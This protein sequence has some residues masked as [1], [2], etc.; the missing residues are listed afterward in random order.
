MNHQK[1]LTKIGVFSLCFWLLGFFV[2]SGERVPDIGV[3]IFEIA[4]M[5]S[6]TFVILSIFYIFIQG[7]RFVF[8]NKEQ[9]V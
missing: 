4:M 5:T 8:K 6:I 3:N 1:N 9:N 2:D 7:V